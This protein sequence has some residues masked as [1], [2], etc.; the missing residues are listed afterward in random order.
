MIP[1]I[2]LTDGYT[3]YTVKEI[4]RKKEYVSS[5]GNTV[6]RTVSVAQYVYVF[7]SCTDTLLG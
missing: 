5:S 1:T 3:T 6:R 2:R 7:L 4:I